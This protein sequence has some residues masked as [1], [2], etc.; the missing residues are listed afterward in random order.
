MW[1]Y[2]KLF[3]VISFS[4]DLNLCCFSCL[5]DGKVKHIQVQ[6]VIKCRVF[7]VLTV[8]LIPSSLVC[9][10]WLSNLNFM[11]VSFNCKS[12]YFWRDLEVG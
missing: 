6:L 5:T 11:S 8:H 10:V 12:L 7:E 1:S 3:S 2:V 9:F 4:E